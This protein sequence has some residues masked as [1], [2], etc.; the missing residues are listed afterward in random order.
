MRAKSV[1]TVS[2]LIVALCAMHSSARAAELPADQIF[3][4]RIHETPTDPESEVVFVVK[5]LLEA[6]DLEGDAVGWKVEKITFREPG[7]GGAPDSVWFEAS[8]VVRSPDGLWWVTHEDPQ[9]PTLDEFDD[10]PLLEGTA[11]AEDPQAEDLEYAFE[12]AEY[13]GSPPYVITGGLTYDFRLADCSIIIRGGENEPVEID[14][15]RDS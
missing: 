3:E 12:G 4:Y 15:D 7:E 5:L 2:A 8:P 1:F 9:S 10:P 13:P 6:A 14:D 11:A